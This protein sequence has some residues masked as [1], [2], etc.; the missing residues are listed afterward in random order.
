MRLNGWVLPSD[1]RYTAPY[2]ETLEKIQVPSRQFS[3]PL[4]FR[5]SNAQIFFE[6]CQ[7]LSRE[8]VLFQDILPNLHLL[9]EHKIG[10][11]NRYLESVPRKDVFTNRQF[12]KYSRYLQSKRARTVDI[13]TILR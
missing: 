11:W 12:V 6:G 5:D 10:K 1:S 7:V 9:I 13:L 8:V 4:P 2:T 3:P